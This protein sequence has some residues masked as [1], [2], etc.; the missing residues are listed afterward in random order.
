LGQRTNPLT[1]GARCATSRSSDET[2]IENNP[3]K[4]NDNPDRAHADQA[5]GRSRHA[6]AARSDKTYTRA[7]IGHLYEMHCKGSPIIIG[8]EWQRIENDIFAVGREGRILGHLN[9]TRA[10]RTF[11]VRLHAAAPLS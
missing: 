8:A 1:A 7:E 3:D 4:K 10:R 9:L 11:D 2:I 5:P 6:A